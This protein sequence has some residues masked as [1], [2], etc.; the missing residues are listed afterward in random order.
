MIHTHK[1]RTS[2]RVTSLAR[3][4]SIAHGFCELIKAGSQSRRIVVELMN[5][6]LLLGAYCVESVTCIDLHLLAPAHIKLLD[7]SIRI[8][9]IE[10]EMK[11][12]LSLGRSLE[13]SMMIVN[14]FL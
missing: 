5:E 3:K 4:T 1:H 7:H 6:L 9:G 8:C 11:R 12:Q 2:Q 10:V 13:S 14:R